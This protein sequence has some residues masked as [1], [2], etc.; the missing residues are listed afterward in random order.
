MLEEIM[1]NYEEDGALKSKCANFIWKLWQISSVMLYFYFVFKGYNAWGLAAIYFTATC[2]IFIVTEAIYMNKIS[3]KLNIDYNLKKDFNIAGEKRMYNEIEKY[4]KNWITLFLKRRGI[5][6]SNKLYIL[7]NEIKEKNSKENIKYIDGA[8]IS[9]VLFSLFPSLFEKT[10]SGLNISSI[11]FLYIVISIAT[12]IIIGYIKKSWIGDKKFFD[13]YNAF[14]S[15]ERLEELIF[16][17]IMK[18]KG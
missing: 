8:I 9:A 12:S 10:I 17:R 15:S 16:Y 6:K 7:L 3:K 13:H 1:K 14:S 2:V 18:C 11:L 5:N 4:Q